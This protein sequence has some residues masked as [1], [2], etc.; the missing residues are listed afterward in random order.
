ME[1]C[2]S[3]H[4]RSRHLFLGLAIG[5]GAYDFGGG[6]FKY[7]YASVSSKKERANII[8]AIG[9]YLTGEVAIHAL[10][11]VP[12]LPDPGEKDSKEPM[13]IPTVI[14]M[15]CFRRGPG[16]GESTGLKKNSGLPSWMVNSPG[17]QFLS[18][19]DDLK[20]AMANG[21]CC[22]RTQ[23]ELGGGGEARKSRR[24]SPV[25]VLCCDDLRS[26]NMHEG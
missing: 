22:G 15:G 7:N 12:P 9:H 24:T 14:R 19:Y 10:L 21:I 11:L 5:K 8:N 6:R 17:Q 23:S 2:E 18:V 20:A 3:F 26:S 4:E 13:Y 16:T 1:L 25:A